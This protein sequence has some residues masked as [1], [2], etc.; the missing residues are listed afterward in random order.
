MSGP[1]VLD[2]VTSPAASG[3]RRVPRDRLEVLTALI[4]GPRF[5]PLFRGEVL[6]FPP[7]HPTY[8]WGCLV[9]GCQRSRSYSYAPDLCQTHAR[10]WSQAKDAG[11]AYPDFVLSAQPLQARGAVGQLL[12]RICP[13]RPATSRDS[14]LCRRHRLRWKHARGRDPS[15]QL[16]QWCAGEVT[17]DGFGECLAI[18][19][20]DLAISPLG[21]CRWHE[22]AYDR[23][24]RPG[25]ARL[26]GAWIRR[27][28]TI[29]RPVVVRYDDR[30]AFGRWCALAPSDTTQGRLDLR[31]LRPLMTEELRW[32]LFRHTEGD[33]ARWTLPGAQSLVNLCRRQQVGTLVDLDLNTC[34]AAVTLIVKEM[35]DELRLVYFAPADTRDAGFLETE[36][37]GVR[38]PK[39]R[40]HYD[41][42]AVSQ[43]WLRG[44]LWDFLADWLRSPKCP[45]SPSMFDR[46][47]Q[48]IA[49][50]SAFLEIDAPGG[51]HDPTVLREE[52]MHRF[53]ADQRHRE[54][55]GLPS[56]AI[57]G[58]DGQ[59][60]T[61]T[62]RSRAQALAGARRVLRAALESD[63]ADVVGL[64]R[65]FVVAAPQPAYPRSRVRRPFPDDVAHVLADETNLARLAENYD[66]SDLGLRDIWETLIATGRRLGEVVNLRL[67][68]TARYNGLP[69]LWHDQT[70]V[71][72]YDE[73]IRIPDTVEQL[74]QER[75]SKT[76]RKFVQWNGREPTAAERSTLALFVTPK[77]NRNATKAIDLSTFNRAFR[78]W[79]D[80]LDLGARYVS[81]QARHTLATNLLRHGADLHHI[82]RYLGHVSEIMTEQYA[83]IALSEIEDILQHV[84][85]AGPGSANPG[86]V[87][88]TATTPMNRQQAHA[89]AVNLSRRS[90]PAEGG[91]C[92]FQPVVHGNA[93]PWNL[94]CHNCDKFV[95]S[96]ADLL[97]WRRKREQ[98]ASIAE[99]APDDA[100]ADYLHQVFEPTARAI[101]GLEKALSALGLLDEALALDLRRPQ[102][103]FNRIWATAFRATDLADHPENDPADIDR[104]DIDPAGI[105]GDDDRVEATA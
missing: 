5:D 49:E 68:C 4:G 62:P 87:L 102:D 60:T 10:Q 88:S 33:R 7:D 64:G 79:V 51:A 27:G 12:C 84:W 86:E 31:G 53:V 101:D 35:L 43:R 58:R 93:C 105:D 38:F 75:R 14:G 96:G 81:H 65:G 19:C 82:R 34:T 45:R 48:A 6:V 29:G 39:R 56:L 50:L 80:E 23:H 73:A 66:P 16:E 28:E 15:L 90:T 78:D 97:Y 30:A 52:H 26:P 76:I 92:T 104:D 67:D 54:R 24:D 2:V 21:L 55:E 9:S 42:T 94:D 63:Q 20:S 77:R 71:G 3:D 95:L 11:T 13:Q 57:R 18:A 83:K 74:L 32:G 91:F 1:V 36:H 59:P 25:G 98:W 89:L 46:T 17:F 47:R 40:G 37:F 44:M 72:N 8:R 61:V 69:M 100:T 103:Y 99:R 22:L 70:K 41:L 85:V